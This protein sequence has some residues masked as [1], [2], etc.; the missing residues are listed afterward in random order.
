MPAALSE[1]RV[2]AYWRDGFL[3]P[4]DVLRPDEA[5]ALRLA[6]GKA[7]ARAGNVGGT[8]RYMFSAS[9]LPIREV[10]ELV[11]D[12]RVLDP[13]ESVLGPD[14]MLWAAGFFIRE[15]RTA[16]FMSW[17]QD[18][19]YW[20]LDDEAHELT[21]WVAIGDATP[22]N[23]A[24]RFIP[25]SHTSGLK[26][27][28][29]TWK[30]DN[31]LS[32]GQ[33]LDVEVDESKAVTAALRAGQISLHHGGLFHASSANRTDNRRIGLAPRYIGLDMKQVTG[34]VD[35]ARLV[36]GEDRFGH[37]RPEPEPAFDF[38]PGRLAAIDAMPRD[39]DAFFY[40]GVEERAPSHDA[41]VG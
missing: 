1:D 30:D 38:D 22:E 18:L 6:V 17:H 24:M 29:D 41:P 10:D 5:E 8:V 23:C 19:R 7:Q 20:G 36:R 26:A 21:A 34:P 14:I 9:H 35:Y 3:F 12:P 33:V 16:D 40:A 27:H 37:F 11:A 15:P 13:V 2:A 31:Q 25:G 28:R 32:R 39:T 4:L